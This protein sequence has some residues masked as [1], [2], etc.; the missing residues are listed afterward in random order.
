MPV[1][2]QDTRLKPYEALVTDFIKGNGHF[3]LITD[4]RLFTNV[5]RKTIASQLSLGQTCIT[6]ISQQLRIMRTVKEMG[7]RK[8]KLIVFIEAV[9][10]HVRSDSLIR[11]IMKTVRNAKVIILTPE[12]ELPKLALLHEIGSNNLITKPIDINTLIVKIAYT[13]K[14]PTELD[15]LVGQAQQCLVEGSYRF[16]LKMCGRIF[17][18]KPDSAAGLMIMGDAYNGLNE[19]E[20]A[21][22]AYME[23]HLKEE[24]YLEPIKRLADFYRG[25]GDRIEQLKFLEKLDLLSPLNAERKVEIGG[26]HLD[27]GNKT[28]ANEQF[29]EALSLANREGVADPMHISERI[30]E[31]TVDK[32][33][34]MSEAYYRKIIKAKGDKLS[35]DDVK[36]FNGLGLALR[37]QGNWRNA[38]EEYR[39]ALI[40][41]PGSENLY[42]NL[43]LAYVDG[44]MY[45]NAMKCVLKADELKVDFHKQDYV[46]SYNFARIMMKCDK[47]KESK[48]F[49]KDALA[50]NPD[51][52]NSKKLL[53]S[54][55]PVGEA[56]S[57]SDPEK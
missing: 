28:L 5:F 13:L 3:V 2:K 32:D 39:K 35:Y 45:P 36:L 55:D 37:K 42:Y 34:H 16:A 23:A 30:G 51:H 56:T 41:M 46:I 50:I 38:V 40:I 7:V 27:L 33:P 53:A 18:M 26:V 17:E 31:V 57:P 1:I 9:L 15:K 47:P 49:V 25:Q 19:K 6:A 8:K 10:D 29:E 20:K 43:A 4:D 11:D 48:R 14:P 12:T 44:K 21:R 52:E 24:L 54:L 22:E